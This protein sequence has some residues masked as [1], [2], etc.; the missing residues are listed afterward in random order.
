MWSILHR[1]P[2]YV[3]TVQSVSQSGFLVT[4]TWD[5]VTRVF[6]ISQVKAVATFVGHT[7][8]IRRAEITPDGRYVITASPTFRV[9]GQFHPVRVSAKESLR[10]SQQTARHP[11]DLKSW[12]FD[13]G[14]GSVRKWDVRCGSCVFELKRHE[15]W[16]FSSS[17]DGRYV[18]LLT[19][20][21]CDRKSC[22]GRTEVWDTE[23]QSMV[24]A[25]ASDV[26]AG[27]S[28]LG[29]L[30]SPPIVFLRRGADVEAISLTN[31][32]CRFRIRPEK[33]NTESVKKADRVKFIIANEDETRV[34]VAFEQGPVE[35]WD[36]DR[37]CRLLVLEQE[38]Q[39]AEVMQFSHVDEMLLVAANRGGLCVVS[40]ATGKIVRAIVDKFYQG[41]SAT[42]SHDGRHI[43]IQEFGRGAR[44]VESVSGSVV[45]ELGLGESK[46]FK[47]GVLPP[48]E[49]LYVPRVHFSK[50]GH[51]LT[52]AHNNPIVWVST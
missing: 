32:D 30:S 46:G 39:D 18:A 48:C 11:L 44:M 52:N 3:S 1:L 22:R 21:E 15:L 40:A 7:G 10:F 45:A 14:D 33:C 13:Q 27:T 26:L 34:A 16:Q 12:E 42:I 23:R 8:F 37:G 38:T 4:C 47:P 31:G 25:I 19:P 24:D 41:D 36:A 28:P 49:G 50:L 17:T 51:C 2:G 35:I 9:E 6:D 43:L 29:F 5:R 20:E